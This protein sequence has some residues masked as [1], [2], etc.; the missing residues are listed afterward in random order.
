MK[1]TEILRDEHA[2]I[3]TALSLLEIAAMRIEREEPVTPLAPLVEFFRVF[4]DECHHAKEEGVLFPEL[5]QRGLP[6]EGG[7]LGVMLA[8]HD[9]GRRLLALLAADAARLDEPDTRARFVKSAR[10]YVTLLGRHIE[11]ENRVLFPMAEHYLG[12]A[13]DRWVVAGFATYDRERTGVRQRFERVLANLERSLK[14]A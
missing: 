13:Q 2:L 7:P 8:E 3:S 14:A 5:A 11:K 12:E 9:L 4:A 10:D 1:A 6:V